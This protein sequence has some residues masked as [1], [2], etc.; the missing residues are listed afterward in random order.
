[1]AHAPVAADVDQ[2]LDVDADFLA[3]V[4]LDLLPLLD[5]LAD[6]VDLV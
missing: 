3:E 2:P 6:L 1:V 4:A 5:D